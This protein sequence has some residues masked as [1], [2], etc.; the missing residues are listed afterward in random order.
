M[1][2]N[3]GRR[4]GRLLA[5]L[6]LAAA[7]I[8]AVTLLTILGSLFP[9]VSSTTATDPE[10][11]VLWQGAVRARYGEGAELLL[12]LGAFRFARSWLYL[13]PVAALTV[14]TLV[15]ATGRWRTVWRR[16]LDR[17]VYC[18]DE[19]FD[20]APLVTRVTADTAVKALPGIVSGNLRRLGFR[21][22]TETRGDT[23]YLRGDRNHLA[24]LGSLLNHLAVILLVIGAA[25][26]AGLVWR[27]EVT[28][29]QGEAVPFGREKNLLVRH[30]GFWT[31]LY[32]DGSPA[33]YEA[34]IALL[35]QGIVATS[36]SVQPNRPLRYG[37]YS[38]YLASYWEIG[39]RNYLFLQVVDDPGYLPLMVAGALMLLG[40]T[41]VLYF[42]PCHVCARVGP[43]GTLRLAGWAHRQAC[44]FEREFRA[45]VTRLENEAAAGNGDGNRGG[46]AA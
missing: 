1:T 34:Q 10:R 32:P 37:G 29:A 4:I 12:K 5:R 41:V 40:M 22:R 19:T 14:T 17:P 11:L 39:G 24:Q 26:S 9:Q 13:I 2:D 42:P 27:E 8:G 35:D 28:V 23:T 25:L 15:C 18:P 30:D 6:D 46:A 3:V 7:L 36:D 44:G 20:A 43:E 45:L 16:A 38:V 31:E 33:A 21:V